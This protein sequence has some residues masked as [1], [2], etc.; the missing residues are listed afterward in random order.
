MDSLIQVISVTDG[1]GDEQALYEYQHFEPHLTRLGLR[2]EA[3]KKRLM[4]ATGERLCQS[5]CTFQ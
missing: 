3:G 5:K 4:L 1:N 2:R